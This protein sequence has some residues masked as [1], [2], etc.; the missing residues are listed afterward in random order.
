MYMCAH[1]HTHIHV[2]IYSNSSKWLKNNQ[3]FIPTWSAFALFSLQRLHSE[4]SYCGLG[5]QCRSNSGCSLVAVTMK[6][7]SLLPCKAELCS[8]QTTW[9][10][11]WVQKTTPVGARQAWGPQAARDKR[12]HIWLHLVT[13][14]QLQLGHRG[15]SP[16]SDYDKKGPHCIR[17]LSIRWWYSCL[18]NRLEEHPRLRNP[19]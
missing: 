1:M 19:L 5:H 4:A 11:A 17:T 8:L 10:C 16:E 12:S 2:S 15:D 13:K 9:K 6:V 18:V 7:N 3:T 14:R